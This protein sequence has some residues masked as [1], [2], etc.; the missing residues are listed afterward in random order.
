MA[1]KRTKSISDSLRPMPEIKRELDLNA[2]EMQ[3]RAIHVQNETA[4]LPVRKEPELPP[5]EKLF[6]L[7]IDIP[8]SLYFKMKETLGRRRPAV[9]H[10][11]FVVNLIENELNKNE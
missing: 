8:E 1:T 7:S 9:T 2:L 11:A 5:A 6:R 4:P 10:R 3:V